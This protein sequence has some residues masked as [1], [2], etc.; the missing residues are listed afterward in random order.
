MEVGTDGRVEL[1]GDEL[2]RLDEMIHFIALRFTGWSGLE[3]GEVRSELWLKALK[4]LAKH[5]MNLPV[6]ARSCYNRAKDLGMEA[7]RR[8]ER[9]VSESELGSEMVEPYVEEEPLENLFVQELVDSFPKGSPESNYLVYLTLCLGI[10]VREHDE[11]GLTY[12]KVFGGYPEGWRR[13]MKVAKALGFTDD[14]SSGFR[15]AKYGVRER[16]RESLS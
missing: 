7:K 11:R 12:Q 1:E 4:V 16:L 2:S 9:S 10:H 15:R 13:D 6:V 3:Y 14:T 8:R 5:G